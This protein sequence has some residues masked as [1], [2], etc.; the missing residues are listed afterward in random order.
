MPARGA[1][2]PGDHQPCLAEGAARRWG[3]LPGVARGGVRGEA[4]FVNGTRTPGGERRGRRALAAVVLAALAAFTSCDCGARTSY[5]D[6]PIAVGSTATVGFYAECVTEESF[7]LP[8]RD[9]ITADC[10][11][12]RVVE[13]TRAVIP[14]PFEVVGLA[15]E[16]PTPS[17]A[18]RRTRG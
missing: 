15:L 10:T 8:T 17:T 7:R 5:T 1:P 2:D 4:F 11:D 18:S 6:K 9:T 16:A 3:T 14:P 12:E 13:L